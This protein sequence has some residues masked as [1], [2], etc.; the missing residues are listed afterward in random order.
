MQHLRQI[1]D[2]AD[3]DND[4]KLSM[5]EFCI[6][7]HLIVC[8]S[9]KGLAIPTTVPRSLAISGTGAGVSPGPEAGSGP[10]VTSG[11]Q[12]PVVRAMPV[13]QPL[14]TP[15]RAVS[16]SIA[17]LTITDRGDAFRQVNI[18]FGISTI[19]SSATSL[20]A[21]WSTM[22]HFILHRIIRNPLL[23]LCVTSSCSALSTE[24]PVKS[25]TSA[26]G[27]SSSETDKEGVRSA[28]Q[29]SL[30]SSFQEPGT[31][32]VQPQDDSMRRSPDKPVA[33]KGSSRDSTDSSWVASVSP[34]VDPQELTVASNALLEVAQ[35]VSSS[36][37]QV[38][39][40]TKGLYI[41]CRVI[42]C[43]VADIYWWRVCMVGC[44]SRD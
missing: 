40:H 42:D 15:P 43:D 29:V 21:N 6:G 13:V 39:L 17:A 35:R 4:T 31:T 26:V 14:S 3:A 22:L 7:M 41:F 36:Q 23:D 34:Q 30:L 38:Q 5:P 2:L 32:N 12:L 9:K 25:S 8:A 1:W 20:Q 33:S 24:L 27:S 19:I 11:L 18:V 44:D 28:S 37:S 16:S 10:A